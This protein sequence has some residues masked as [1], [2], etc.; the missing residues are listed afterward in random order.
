M[1][2]VQ[3]SPLNACPPPYEKDCMS[4]SARILK[5]ISGSVFYL[6][7]MYVSQWSRVFKFVLRCERSRFDTISAPVAGSSPNLPSPNYKAPS[8][9][10]DQ[11]PTPQRLSR[12]FRSSS[13]HC[14]MMFIVPP[15]SARKNHSMC[16][17]SVSQ[18]HIS[19]QK[20]IAPRRL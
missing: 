20:R 7:A 8:C 5:L 16:R 2:S 1:C 10:I 3:M 6:L 12:T 4:P 13:G 17:L 14:T 11:P 18:T 9:A 15:E 19:R